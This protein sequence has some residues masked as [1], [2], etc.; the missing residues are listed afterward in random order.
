MLTEFYEYGT[1]LLES[2]EGAFGAALVASF[3]KGGEVF[4]VE[5]VP[6]F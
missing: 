2:D 4:G 3:E 1:V 5:G 6:L